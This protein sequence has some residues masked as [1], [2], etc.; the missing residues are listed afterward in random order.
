MLYYIGLSLF[1]I[2][3]TLAGNH[4]FL[5]LTLIVSCCSSDFSGFACWLY[6][7]LLWFLLIFNCCLTSS[8]FC[9]VG[10]NNVLLVG[11]NVLV[12]LPNNL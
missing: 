1:G 10:Y 3:I 7:C 2:F 8:G 6:I 5:S 9:V 12:L 11:N 4:L